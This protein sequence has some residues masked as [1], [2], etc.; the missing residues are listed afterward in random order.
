MEVLINR[1]KKLAEESQEFNKELEGLLEKYERERGEGEKEENLPSVEVTFPTLMENMSSSKSN[2]ARHKSKRKERFADIKVL[3]PNL[4]KASKD[5]R[6]YYALE[7]MTKHD[8]SLYLFNHKK[9]FLAQS[10]SIYSGITTNQFQP[11][12]AKLASNRVYIRP[13]NQQ[14]RTGT[15][16]SIDY[17]RT[18]SNPFGHSTPSNLDLMLTERGELK[19]VL[20]NTGDLVIDLSAEICKVDA[21]NYN[22]SNFFR[23]VAKVES[24]KILTID[25]G[26]LVM[27]EVDQRLLRGFQIVLSESMNINTF[28]GSVYGNSMKV[29][30]PGLKSKKTLPKIDRIKEYI[31]ALALKANSSKQVIL[32]DVKVHTFELFKMK[33]LLT[34]SL[35]GDIH[36]LVGFIDIFKISDK[37]K[38]TANGWEWTAISSIAN[39]VLVGGISQDKTT[40]RLLLMDDHLRILDEAKY[41]S[42]DSLPPHIFFVSDQISTPTAFS[43]ALSFVII[44]T[45][46]NITTYSIYGSRLIKFTTEVKNRQELHRPLQAA[47]GNPAQLPAFGGNYNPFGVAPHQGL[48]AEGG[49]EDNMQYGDDSSDELMM[50]AAMEY[51]G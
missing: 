5:L 7:R 13:I 18:D 51:I 3:K 20:R 1:V 23:D 45:Q 2:P 12:N 50:G 9:S 39:Y 24:T 38:I 46:D 37:T 6:S 36:K 25:K 34:L 40:S 4:D 33:T 43:T 21:M 31:D 47:Q 16:L 26:Q 35:E 8:W 22:K 27:F 41:P 11:M 15:V 19:V 10:K 44:D 48:F 28:G 42:V 14:A 17:S 30:L 32:P 49:D 29:N